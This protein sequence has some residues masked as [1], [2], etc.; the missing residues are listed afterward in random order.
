[1]NFQLSNPVVDLPETAYNF[2]AVSI[3]LPFE[4]KMKSKRDLTVSLQAALYKIEKDL[5]ARFS[6]EMSVLVL[7]KLKM[8]LKD[9]NYSTHKKSI[10]IYVSPVFEKVIYLNIEVDKKTLV[11]TS[12]HI[13]DLVK[14]KKCSR[15]YLLLQLLQSESRIYAVSYTHLTLPTILR[16]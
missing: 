11:G 10:A 16:V 3:V 13:R 14:S 8:V 7:Q 2:P 9:L 4:P 15:E 6:V 5:F 12:F 1:M